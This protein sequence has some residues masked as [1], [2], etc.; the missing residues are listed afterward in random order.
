MLKCQEYAPGRHRSFQALSFANPAPGIYFPDHVTSTIEYPDIDTKSRPVPLY[1]ERASFRARTIELNAADHESLMQHIDLPPGTVAT[2][3]VTQAVFRVGESEH[4]LADALAGQVAKITELRQAAPLPVTGVKVPLVAGATIVALAVV[5]C[6]TFRRWRRAFG[7]ISILIMPTALLRASPQSESVIL[8]D[9]GAT[10]A[11]NCG[12]NTTALVLQLYQMPVSIPDLARSLGAGAQWQYP[13]NMLDVKKT[14][15]AHGLLVESFRDASMDDIIREVSAPNT[16]AVMHLN[17]HK[18]YDQGHYLIFAAATA[19]HVLVADPG[20][21]TQ[22]YPVHKLAKY[23]GPLMSGVVLI[24]RERPIGTTWSLNEESIPVALGDFA[25]VPGEL[26]SRIRVRN[27]QNHPLKILHAESSCSCFL[28]GGFTSGSGE[29]LAVLEPHAEANLDMRFDRSKFSLGANR[30]P[31]AVEL[32]CGD[33]ATR[34]VLLEVSAFVTEQGHKSE[35]RWLP[36]VVT[37]VL[38]IGVT[39]TKI[40]SD[41]S[42]LSVRRTSCGEGVPRNAQFRCECF[43][44]TLRAPRVNMRSVVEFA[45]TDAATPTVRVDVNYLV[46]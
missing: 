39:V 19:D 38:P 41:E 29:E 40:T 30:R 17:A 25:R 14:L 44:I 10:R 43:E 26:V 21:S 33:G 42:V 45:L 23:L 34:N 7:L 12:I 37:I 27:D 11:F 13:V 16:V 9:L 20:R 15:L 35:I 46:R 31:V 1:P 2:D 4:K 36:A 8:P 28:A 5:A 22:W 32:D 18:Q 3:K 6:I 24:V